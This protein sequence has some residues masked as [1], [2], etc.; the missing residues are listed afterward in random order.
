MGIDLDTVLRNERDQ[1]IKDEIEMTNNGGKDV[2]LTL[3]MAMV[4]ALF[5]SFPDEQQS[6]LNEE[7]K[8]KRADL[9]TDLYKRTERVIKP[10]EY[11]KVKKLIGKLYGPRVI[12][13]AFD[14]IDKSAA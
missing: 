2:D 6:G 10:E 9:A 8:Y 14:L 1:A 3:R 13:A 11:A 4:H 12:K 7:E 5:F